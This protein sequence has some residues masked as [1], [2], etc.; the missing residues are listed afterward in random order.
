MKQPPHSYILSGMFNMADVIGLRGKQGSWSSA[1]L[2]G[3]VP[4]DF[5][6][7]GSR[8]GSGMVGFALSCAWKV[9]RH[10]TGRPGTP[11]TPRGRERN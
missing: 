8:Q 6:L 11:G 7:T 9:E 2:C 4:L 3:L 5:G 1:R 10:D